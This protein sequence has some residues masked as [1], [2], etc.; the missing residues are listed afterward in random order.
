[1]KLQTTYFSRA[2]CQPITR[3]PLETSHLPVAAYL[4]YR[5]AAAIH[6]EN[7]QSYNTGLSWQTGAIINPKEEKDH[8]HYSI[9]F[10]ET[11]ASNLLD[12]IIS[13]LREMN[14]LTGEETIKILFHFPLSMSIVLFCHNG[15]CLYLLGRKFCQKCF[16]LQNQQGS[17]LEG[18]KLHP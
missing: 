13:L 11:L 6:L 1:M 5:T 7:K 14:T 17:T 8:H 18:K 9:T 15:K 12:C 3:L 16:C 2:E 4:I 10:S